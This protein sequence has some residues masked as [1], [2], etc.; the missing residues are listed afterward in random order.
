MGGPDRQAW[1]ADTL[2]GDECSEPH[3][4]FPPHQSPNG[5]GLR[6]A[7]NDLGLLVPETIHANKAP[8]D[9][10]THHAV[11]VTPHV[12]T[13][14]PIDEQSADHHEVLLPGILTQSQHPTQNDEAGN[15]CL[16]LKLLFAVVRVW[17]MAMRRL[18]FEMTNTLKTTLL[19]G[20][21]CILLTLMH[22]M[23]SER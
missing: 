7:S 17:L 19:F 3:V 6:P 4:M 10:C 18:G 15:S 16:R 1:H 22:F 23:T 14:V 2:A 11:P 20:S 9:D 21:A 5:S 13:T 8:A 12:H